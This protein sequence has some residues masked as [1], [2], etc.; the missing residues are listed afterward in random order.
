MIAD[1]I[2]PTVRVPYAMYLSFLSVDIVPT[3]LIESIE[4]PTP[5]GDI[6]PF[7]FWIELESNGIKAVALLLK[8]KGYCIYFFSFTTWPTEVRTDRFPSY[9]PNPDP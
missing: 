7:F 6:E 5:A 3:P 1:A 4:L 8:E 2:R 9:D